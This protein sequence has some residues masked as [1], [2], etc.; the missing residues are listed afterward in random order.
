[1]KQFAL[2]LGMLFTAAIPASAT[3]VISCQS[4]DGTSVILQLGFV[5]VD[6][7]IGAT[8]S[9]ENQIWTTDETGGIPV[10]ILQ[11]FVE[12]GKISVDFSDRNLEQIIARLRL[13]TATEGMDQAMAGTLQITDV[14][15]WSV[16][17][18]GP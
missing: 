12:S 10:S 13:L 7:I 8:I 4:D 9:S 11:S 3:G 6:S 14:G 15:V 17:C 2:A 1:M 18:E 5:A 16:T